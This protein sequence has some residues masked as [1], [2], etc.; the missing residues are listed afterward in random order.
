M[1][2]Q[3][4]WRGTAVLHPSNPD[5]FTR[6]PPRCLPPKT[7]KHHRRTVQ[8][9]ETMEPAKQAVDSVAEGV[10]KVAIGGKKDK[11]KGGADGSQR[12][13]EMSPPPDFLQHRLDMYGPPLFRVP[14][15][16]LS[17]RDANYPCL[18]ASRGSRRSTMRRS[19]RSPAIPSRSRCPTAISGSKPP[20]TPSRLPRT[21][22]ATVY[23]H[24]LPQGHRVGDHPR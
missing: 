14:T 19:P 12:A 23:S 8:L 2:V 9:L 13:L 5:R 24:A 16:V 21:H 17:G 1:A 10:K 15:S 11:K 20:R 7:A 3:V 18:A 22:I 4:F 6:Q